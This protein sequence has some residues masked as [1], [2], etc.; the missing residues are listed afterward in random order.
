MHG[1]DGTPDRTM[2]DRMVVSAIGEQQLPNA[3]PA[4]IMADIWTWR[5]A[6]V[7][8]TWDA[9][10]MHSGSLFSRH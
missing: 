5:E 2:Q 3:Q 9:R 7:L 10:V 8:C 4:K 6:S 1:V